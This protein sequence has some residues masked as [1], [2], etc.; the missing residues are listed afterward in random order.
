MEIIKKTILQALT[1][2]TTATG[3]TVIT[4]DTDAVYYIKILLTQDT[5][6]VGFF[7]VYVE[8]VE[9]EPETFVFTDGEGN[10]L[11]DGEGDNLIY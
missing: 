9:P 5:R 6:D 8:P 11:V 4:G 2:G 3:G 7:D 1:T 10:V